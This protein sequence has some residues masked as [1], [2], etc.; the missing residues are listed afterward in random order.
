VDVVLAADVDL[1]GYAAVVF[2]GE[3][4]L[5]YV[6]EGSGAAAAAAVIERMRKVGKVVGAICTGEGVLAHHGFLDGKEVAPDRETRQRFS[7]ATIPWKDDCV[8]TD[9]KRVTAAEPKD[10]VPL[11]DALLA[12]IRNG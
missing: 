10:A 9:G 2:C 1:S 4:V 6:K 3:H 5:E 12:A 8:V 7:K 11:A